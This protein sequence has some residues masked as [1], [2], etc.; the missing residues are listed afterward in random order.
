MQIL[1]TATMTAGSAIPSVRFLDGGLGTSLEDAYGVHFDEKTPLWSSHLLVSDPETLR[2]CQGDFAKVPVDILSTATYQVSA[3]GFHRAGIAPNAIPKFLDLAVSIAEQAKGSSTKIALSLG[4]YGSVMVP[5]QEYSGD[6][7]EGHSSVDSLCEWHKNRM[8]LFTEVNMIG[9]RV[10]YMAFE[11]VPRLDEILAIRRFT[12]SLAS[13]SK[14]W[15]VPTLGQVPYWISCVFPGDG[16]TLPDGSNITR[17]IHALLSLDI[18]ES[19]PWGI[20]INCTKLA[21]LPQ[22]ID[23]YESGVEV[24]ERAGYLKSRPSLLLYP[25][26]TNGEVYDTTSKTWKQTTSPMQNATKVRCNLVI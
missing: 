9:Q 18:S 14:D 4:P 25:D 24:L 26:G 19:V 21:K 10:D 13:K 17:V 2:S 15:T 23:M 20:G 3:Y 11:T 8:S 22:L 12:A 7:D 16:Y 6:Y 5:S 1:V